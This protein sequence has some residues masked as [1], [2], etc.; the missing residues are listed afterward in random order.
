[1]FITTLVDD[2]FLPPRNLDALMDAKSDAPERPSPLEL[3]AGGFD[4]ALELTNTVEARFSFGSAL[5]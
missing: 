5:L 2:E 4:A 3:M 1:M